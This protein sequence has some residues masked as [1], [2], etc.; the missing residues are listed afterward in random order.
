DRAALQLLYG[1]LRA[2]ALDDE[3][4]LAWLAELDVGWRWGREATDQMG[5]DDS[6]AALVRAAGRWWRR[7]TARSHKA[8]LER[9]SRVEDVCRHQGRQL[10]TRGAAASRVVEEV[11]RRVR[12]FRERVAETVTASGR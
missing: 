2:T 9:A 10:Q 4:A 8:L 3:A 7:P 12:S 11:G 1:W 5:G 6:L